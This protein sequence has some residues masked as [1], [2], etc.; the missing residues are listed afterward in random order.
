MSHNMKNRIRASYGVNRELKL[1]ADPACAAKCENGTFV[2]RH[3]GETI[4]FRGIPFAKPPVGALRWKKP[5]APYAVLTEEGRR[6]T[7]LLCSSQPTARR[8]ADASSG[9]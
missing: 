6:P 7:S 2:G 5:E 1:V 8:A 9:R 3:L 4:A